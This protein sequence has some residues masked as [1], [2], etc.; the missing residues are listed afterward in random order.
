MRK[1][2]RSYIELVAAAFDVPGPIYEFGAL[3]VAGQEGFAD[4]RPFFP[5]RAYVGCDMREGPGVDRVVDL[6]DIRLEPGC[7]GTVLMMDTL[8]HVEYPRRA[9]EGVHRTL[10]DGGMLMMSSVM[11]F[12][13][14]EHPYD[15]WRF[16]PEAFRSLLSQFPVRHVDYAGDPEFPHTVVGVGIKG[17]SPLPQAYLDGLEQWRRKWYFLEG[18]SWRHR[19]RMLLPP[20]LH[21][22]FLR[23]LKAMIWS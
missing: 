9:M 8:E 23:K 10:R 15:Y 17:D 13:I 18:N 6:H 2:I 19:K 16:T 7:A 4:L 3:Q 1:C 22:H 5:G 12:P 20:V 11:N 14:H 21:G